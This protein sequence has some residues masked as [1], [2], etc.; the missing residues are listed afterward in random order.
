VVFHPRSGRAAGS[1]NHTP[2]ARHDQNH[3]GERETLGVESL[4][5]ATQLPEDVRKVGYHLLCLLVWEPGQ[6]WA[7]QKDGESSYP[8]QRGDLPRAALRD[9]LLGKKTVALV[10]DGHGS[11]CRYGALDLDIP[12][13]GETLRDAL[14]LLASLQAAAA[15]RDLPTLAVWSGRRGFHLLLPAAAPV[16]WSVMH[17]TLRRIA[18]D[19]GWEDP[20]EVFPSKGKALKLPGGRHRVT[21]AWSGVLGDI[22][23]PEARDALATAL[24][25]DL[26]AAASTPP[27]EPPEACSWSTQ[28]T[29]LEAFQPASLTPLEAAAGEAS[30]PDLDLLQEGTHPA[31]IQS[32]LESGPL[33]GQVL[34]SENLLLATY[35]VQRGLSEEEAEEMAAALYE[36]FPKGEKGGKATL[37]EEVTTKTP[38]AAARDFQQAYR[39]SQDPSR[40]LLFRCSNAAAG[41]PE[42]A[43]ALVASG[44]CEGEAC[45]CWPWGR[46]SQDIPREP[47]PDGFRDWSTAPEDPQQA[48]EDRPP[49][50]EEGEAHGRRLWQAIQAVLAAGQE[51]TLSLVL[52]AAERVEPEEVSWRS[53][54]WAD[55]LVE[56]EFLSGCLAPGGT[57]LLSGVVLHPAAFATPSPLHWE[58][59]VRRL[60]ERPETSPDVWKAHLERLS[61]LAIRSQAETVA[62]RLLS[63][64]ADRDHQPADALAA[65]TQ[66]VAT[67]LRTVSPDLQPVSLQLA[68]VLEDLVDSTAPRIPVPFPGLSRVLK[69][70]LRAGQLV[71][72]GGPPGCGKTTLSLQLADH[73]AA[74]GFPVVFISMEMTRTQLVQASLSR[75]SELETSV[76]GHALSKASGGDGAASEEQV[77]KAEKALETYLQT[78]APRLYLVEGGPQHTPGRIQAL[79]GQVRH[80]LDLPDRHPVLVVV[81]Y[82]QLLS[83]GS[84]AEGSIREDLRVGALASSLKGLARATGSAVLALSDIT[85]AAME[86]AERGGRIG[87]GVF[88]DSGRI[89]H[90][91][92][93]ALVVQSGTVPAQKGKPAQNLL[94]VALQEP[95]L[96]ASRREQLEEADRPLEHPGDTIARWTVLKNRGGQAGGEVLSLY[97]RHLST[98]HPLLKED[99]GS[100]GEASGGW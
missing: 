40:G 64:M 44:R 57:P 9:H 36:R 80:Q 78:M 88:R 90:A 34:H 7:L 24:E 32:R 10:S 71:T 89:L 18:R 38:G 98:F 11:L 53:T 29:V 85:K 70:G 69:G 73:A 20:A 76:L 83:L 56:E 66:S 52:A 33:P 46:T 84:E 39:D 3:R 22:S 62:S 30:S 2:T 43:R 45:P 68:G 79:V 5:M 77:A 13:D 81:D 47:T 82:L 26:E 100:D 17:R 74:A 42:D 99:R 19:A 50:V 1:L 93:T 14:E 41:G 55:Q 12:R 21:G 58:V 4:T 37:G 54:G 8:H 92:D 61:E 75:I 51:V 72:A 15:A 25:A 97:R 28:A 94:E 63:D 59:W 48:S 95:G 23:T 91:A 27:A 67:L 31:C 16:R 49:L 65:A 6:R 60:V 86:E 35:A 96:P 87:P